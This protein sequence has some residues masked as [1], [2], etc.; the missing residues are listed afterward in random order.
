MGHG[1]FRPGAGRKKGVPNR[2]TLDIQAR[3]AALGCHPIEGMALIAMDPKSPPELRGRMYSELAQYVAPKR[4]AVEM[5]GPNGS[6][7][8]ME[9]VSRPPRMTR[10]EWLRQREFELGAPQRRVPS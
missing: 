5:S 3:L 8:A 2:A 6:P 1:G 7:V 4:K 9:G 10:E